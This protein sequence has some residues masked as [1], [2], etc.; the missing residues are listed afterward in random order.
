MRNFNLEEKEILELIIYDLEKKYPTAKDRK[1]ISLFD[2]LEKMAND[3]K[4]QIDIDRKEKK[5]VLRSDKIGYRLVDGKKL[6]IIYSNWGNIF[7]IHTL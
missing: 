1:R 6:P 5:L 2:L 7:I 3:L 4:V